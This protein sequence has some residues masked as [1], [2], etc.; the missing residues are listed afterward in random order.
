MIK[1]LGVAFIAR[2]LNSLVT[3]GSLAYMTNSLGISQS[4]SYFLFLANITLVSSFLSRGL[5]GAILRDSSR[6]FNENRYNQVLITLFGAI[7][8]IISLFT[9]SMLLALLLSIHFRMTS[10]LFILGASITFLLICSDFIT[11]TLLAINRVNLAI[12]MQGFFMSV[13]VSMCIFFYESNLHYTFVI[14]FYGIGV[15][16]NCIIGFITIIRTVGFENITG[17]SIRDCCKIKFLGANEFWLIKVANILSANIAVVI[18]GFLGTNDDVALLAVAQ[19]VV[20]VLSLILMTINMIFSSK[21]SVLSNGG[22]S[23]ELRLF[24]GLISF[25]I[26]VLT[27]PIVVTMMTF[28]EELLALFGD[29][30]SDASGILLLLIIGY[31]FNILVGPTGTVLTLGGF[32]KSYKR[33]IWVCTGV[34]CIIIYPLILWLNVIGAAIGLSLYLVLVN[35]C[36]YLKVLEK[37]DFSTVNYQFLKERISGVKK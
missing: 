2:A 9:V 1:K 5:G 23:S 18:L 19:R 37:F 4:G 6:L 24:V 11:N 25:V 20:L 12:L 16:L 31:V 3:L 29:Q 14:M 27:L 17:I 7:L 32:E 15:L 10:H 34:L 22:S 30:F 33:I 28:S 35:A 13:S 26:L 21:I 36:G 8:R